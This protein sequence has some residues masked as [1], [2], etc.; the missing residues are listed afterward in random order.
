MSAEHEK[1][2]DPEELE[3]L[4]E[5]EGLVREVAEAAFGF[6]DLRPAPPHRP[7]RLR[8]FCDAYG[9]DDRVGLLDAVEALLRD[10]L[11]ETI[12]LGRRGVSPYGVLLARGEDRLRRNGTGMARGEP[13]QP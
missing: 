10:A 6:D 13:T 8:M 12:E 2:E 5:L 7:A 3:D 9:V 11:T 1:P 4:E